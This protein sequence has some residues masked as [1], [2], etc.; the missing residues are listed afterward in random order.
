MSE[1]HSAQLNIKVTS[2]AM[3]SIAPARTT[4]KLRLNTDNLST[5]TTTTT[6]RINRITRAQS[7]SKLQIEPGRVR[8]IK[9]DSST[10]QVAP[11]GRDL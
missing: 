6:L 7:S 9:E 4:S 10:A 11:A 5:T 3:T 8:E 1:R 2:S